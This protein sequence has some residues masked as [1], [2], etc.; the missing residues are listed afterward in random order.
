MYILGIETTGA[1]AS[2]ALVRD[3]VTVQEIHGS[4]R[5]SHLQKTI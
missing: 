2:V 1:F 5:F 4:D 3:G